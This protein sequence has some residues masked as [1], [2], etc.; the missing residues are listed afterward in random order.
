[1]EQSLNNRKEIESFLQKCGKHKKIHIFYLFEGK[2]IN[3][4]ITLVPKNNSE[5]YRISIYSVGNCRVV[6]YSGGERQI[7]GDLNG[8]SLKKAIDYMERNPVFVEIKCNIYTYELRQMCI[9]LSNARKLTY[10]KLAEDK[11]SGYNLFQLTSIDGVSIFSKTNHDNLVWNGIK[12]KKEW[13]YSKIISL[14]EELKN[15]DDVESLMYCDTTCRFE[16]S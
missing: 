3:C 6:K 13:F 9:E 10:Q 7:A 1:M 12:S 4:T 8:K 14:F 2:T 5:N 15:I 11:R 16:Y